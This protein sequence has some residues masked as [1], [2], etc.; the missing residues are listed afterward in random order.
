M[1]ALA[2]VSLHCSAD[3]ARCGALQD[4]V[5]RAVPVLVYTVNA[6]AEV[7]TLLGRGVASVFTDALD[8][9]APQPDT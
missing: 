7:A 9:C 8:D 3:A 1:A 6:P 2:A 5:L 4:V